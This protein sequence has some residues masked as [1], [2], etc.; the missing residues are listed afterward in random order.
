MLV[1]P[2][3][4]VATPPQQEHDDNPIFISPRTSISTPISFLQAQ[5]TPILQSPYQA[6]NRLI[7]YLVDTAE[8]ELRL[9]LGDAVKDKA[10]LGVV[11][12]S[13]KVARLLDMHNICKNKRQDST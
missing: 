11:Q 7:I 8:L 3:T 12:Q 10:T 9:L 2:L 6:N 13:E 1:C 5:P 4:T